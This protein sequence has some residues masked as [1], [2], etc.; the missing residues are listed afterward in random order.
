[1]KCKDCEDSKIIPFGEWACFRW[2]TVLEKAVDDEGE[3]F[4]GMTEARWSDV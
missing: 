4:K 3:C 1:M 2:C